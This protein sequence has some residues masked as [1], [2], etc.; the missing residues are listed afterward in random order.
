[1]MSLNTAPCEQKGLTLVEIMIALLLGVFLLG[2]VIEIFL[3]SKKTYRVQ[4]ALSRLQENGRFAM[5]FIGRDVRMADYRACPSSPRLTDAVDPVN[6]KNGAAGTNRAN[7]LPDSISIK[8]SE[9]ACGALGTPQNRF[10]GISSAKGLYLNNTSNEMV[11]GVENMQI[12]YG[13]DTDNDAVPNYYVEAGA[14]GL[15]LTQVVSVRVSLL[16]R[17]IDDNITTQ[18]LP[19]TYNG[20][21][22]TPSD[23]RIRRV[24]NSTIALRNR[25]H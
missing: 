10:Y 3:N 22:T 7:D 6:C 21:A 12:L 9:L 15:D 4:E 16:L 8:W 14:A 24:F 18:P 25:L 20:T 1:M 5:D 23:H 11:E 17:T 13:A 2:G 19:Y